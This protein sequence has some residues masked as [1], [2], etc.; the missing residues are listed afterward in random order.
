MSPGSLVQEETSASLLKNGAMV[1]LS[2][3]MGLTR[4]AV[5]FVPR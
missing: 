5:I 2:A 4:L 3:R 1:C